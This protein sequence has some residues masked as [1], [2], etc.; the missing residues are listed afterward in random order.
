MDL[1]DSLVDD[2]AVPKYKIKK[3][4]RK[5]GIT[6]S[7]LENAIQKLCSKD[8]CWP[9]IAEQW[10]SQ[11]EEGNSL[12]GHCV[13]A[14]LVLGDYVSNIQYVK[15]DIRFPDGK[16]V[17][18]CHY[19]ALLNGEEL[20]ITR[21]QFPDRT[22]II[23]KEIVSRDYILSLPDGEKERYEIFKQRVDEFFFES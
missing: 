1:Q 15:S 9:P 2:Y 7:D 12:F 5:K 19:F 8:T 21:F 13:M 14:T 20:D 23:N 4:F 17:E 16:L 6:E 3:E 22:M 18:G 10:E 11:N